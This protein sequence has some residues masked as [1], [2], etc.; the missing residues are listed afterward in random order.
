MKA[1]KAI[2]ALLILLVILSCQAHLQGISPNSDKELSS[3]LGP[4][5][6]KVLVSSYPNSQPCKASS[7][8]RWGAENACPK[9]F[10]SA[11]EIT[12]GGKALFV[13]LSAFVDLGNPRAVQIYLRKGKGSFAVVLTGGDAA[14]S[15]SATLEFQS[16]HLNIREV[17]H[18]EFP[19]EA[20]ERTHYKFNIGN[21]N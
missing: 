20:W 17:H 5:N 15:Y 14:T 18:G 8:W 11:L 2:I 7:S 4:V 9:T 10:I 16:D 19:S 3:T 12:A 6:V 1:L 13:P 21:Q